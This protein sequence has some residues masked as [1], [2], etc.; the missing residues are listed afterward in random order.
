MVDPIF[1]LVGAP[2]ILVDFGSKP[3]W[4]GVFGELATHVRTYLAWIGSRSHELDFDKPNGHVWADR[5]GAL[6]IPH[7]P[8]GKSARKASGG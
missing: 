6:A 5:N 1:W 3:F 8:K 7:I 2:A 4:E